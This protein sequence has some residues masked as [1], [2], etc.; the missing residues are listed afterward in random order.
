MTRWMRQAPR[1]AVATALAL[2]SVLLFVGAV[3]HITDL[4][5]H[6]LRPY[7]WAPNWLNLYWTSL[8][9]LDPLAAGLLISGRRRGMDLC[10]AIMAT[11]ITANW[12]AVYGIQHSGLH[13]QSGLQRLAVFTLLVLLVAPFLRRHLA[14]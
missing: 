6:G 12:Y 7:E 4:L 11:D 1:W 8:A 14:D 10:C 3:S 9:F 13:A 5:R 2:A